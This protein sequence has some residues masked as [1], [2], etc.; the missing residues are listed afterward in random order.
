MTERADLTDV[1]RWVVVRLVVSP[2]AI[3]GLLALPRIY[4]A[5]TTTSAT[6]E[7]TPAYLALN[8]ALALLLNGL[9]LVLSRWSATLGRLILVVVPLTLF[10]VR[11]INA[12]LLRSFGVRYSA[13]VFA[14]L[15]L[16]TIR[17][18][19]T[20]YWAPVLLVTLCL[21][22]LGVV[23]W[24]VRWPVR[25]GH[26]LAT[27]AVVAYL[28]ACLGGGAVLVQFGPPWAYRAFDSYL[29]AIQARGY[30][31]GAAVLDRLEWGPQ[32][33]E[34]LRR[35]GLGFADRDPVDPAPTWRPSNLLIVY[36]ES[37]RADWS[38]IGGSPH[39][40]VTPRLDRFASENT[41]A[42][43]HYSTVRP[44]ISSLVSGQ[45]GVLSE[46]SNLISSGIVGFAGRVSC[47]SDILHDRGYY[48]LLLTAI[49]KMFAGT[50]D[51]A[52]SHR[53]DE[54]YGRKEW[55]EEDA[56]YG[57]APAWGLFD[58][59]LT[60]ATLST[61]DRVAPTAPFHISVMTMDTHGPSFAAPP[62]CPVYADGDDLLNAVH[63]TD[64]AFGRLIDGLV[65][66]GLYQTTNIIVVGDHTPHGDE[67]Y[68]QVFLAIR[69]AGQTQ[70]SRL[71]EIGHTPD[72]APTALEL[73]GLP[74]RTLYAGRSLLSGRAGFTHLVAPSVEVIDGRLRGIGDRCSD[75]ELLATVLTSADRP[76]TACE[77]RKAMAFQALWLRGRA[78]L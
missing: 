50:E 26:R 68:G 71:T 44:T 17:V 65:E 70:A 38:G 73:L 2:L 78:S 29:L 42:E 16:E 75:D 40:A 45:C 52:L 27:A 9:A 32:E 72:L 46:F 4:T 63:C 58:Y 35:L 10:L 7:F 36:L 20:D 55:V 76:L 24:R 31:A 59:D 23:S 47:L 74:G 15:E 43:R 66:R 48:Q 6:E 49:P 39:P 14:H 28:A 25:P 37:F 19:F 77:R 64:F 33:R 62:E 34:V 1:L 53:F 30:Y 41:Y 21:A 3:F 11:A 60:D 5:V 18:G 51:F 8:L 54:L 69:A 12:E 67:L 57:R 61:I 22:C 13:V 56:S